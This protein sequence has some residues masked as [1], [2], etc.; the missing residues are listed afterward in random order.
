MSL[1]F[2]YENIAE[3]LL[4]CDGREIQVQGQTSSPAGRLVELDH[5]VYSSPATHAKLETIS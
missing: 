2:F 3:V 5:S 1:E 4:A